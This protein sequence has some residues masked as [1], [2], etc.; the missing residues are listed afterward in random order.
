[1]TTNSF[2]SS[3]PRFDYPTIQPVATKASRIQGLPVSARIVTIAA[4]AGLAYYA[5]SQVQQRRELQFQSQPVEGP[6]SRGPVASVYVPWDMD[7][8]PSSGRA[9]NK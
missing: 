2:G 1:M 7:R 9:L 5:T 6:Q 8:Q 3:L 4:A